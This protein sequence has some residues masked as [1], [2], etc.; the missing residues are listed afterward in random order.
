MGLD[1]DKFKEANDKFGHLYG[2]EVLKNMADSIKRSIR[3]GDIAARIGGDEFLIFIE[4][5]SAGEELAERIF[6]SLS[7]GS[8][9]YPVSIS[10][11]AVRI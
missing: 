4:S 5:R 9:G 6:R 3:S 1:L 8:E 7:D 10:M 2:G 11:G